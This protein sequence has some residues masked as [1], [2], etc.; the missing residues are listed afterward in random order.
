MLGNPTAGV[1][2][3]EPERAAEPN[4]TIPRAFADQLAMTLEWA[5][6]RAGAVN[7]EV[8]RKLGESAAELR[9]Y[10]EVGDGGG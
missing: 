6:P 4:V 10:L 5:A 7:P 9:G 1:S 8:G 3:S 2:W